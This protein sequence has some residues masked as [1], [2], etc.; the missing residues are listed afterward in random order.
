MTLMPQRWTTFF[1]MP[2]GRVAVVAL[3]LALASGETAYG[4]LRGAGNER[5]ALRGIGPI[6]V[7][8]GVDEES[9]AHGL[10]EEA[11]QAAVELQLRRNGV[12]LLESDTNHLVVNIGV[13]DAELFGFII[14]TYFRQAAA[15]ISSNQVGNYITW[16]RE[17]FGYVSLERDLRDT[18]RENISQHIDI[19]SNDYLAV[20]PQP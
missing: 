6:N 12:P 14:Q 9:V 18:V 13:I 5:L 17:H 4:Q 3:L 8:I 10:T 15:V 19:F 1:T 7:V 16:H 11:L 2:V 20:N